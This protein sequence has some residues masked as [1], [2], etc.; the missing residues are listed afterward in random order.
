MNDRFLP[1]RAALGVVHVVALI[2]HHRFNI[3]Q[4]IIRF[5]RFGVK[6]VAE[7]FRGH[8]HD[9]SVSVHTEVA[10]HQTDF[11]V[12]ELLAKITQLLV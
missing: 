9:R 2:K 6:H 10:G 4:R 12:T 7:D 11:L 3:C 1:H 5:V 8:H